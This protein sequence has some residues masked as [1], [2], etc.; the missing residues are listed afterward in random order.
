MAYN[1]NKPQSS[2]VPATSQADILANFIAIKTLIDVNHATFSDASEGKHKHVSLPEQAASPATLVNE[3]A[4]FS[5]QSALTGVAELCLRKE[6]NGTVNEIAYGATWARLSS[7]ILLKW[8]TITANGLATITFP[9]AAN[10]PAFVTLLSMQLTIGD[11]GITDS[12][13]AIRIISGTN[14][15]FRVYGSPR[16]TA[17]AKNVGFNY[18]AIGL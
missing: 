7:G 1:A 5:R 15:A 9:V 16:T 4:L 8:G 11:T 6:N 14:L 2:D 18:L 13:S 17:G 12:N 3:I 10:I